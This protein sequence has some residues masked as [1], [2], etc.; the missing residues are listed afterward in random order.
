MVCTK[1]FQS[2]MSMIL[3]SHSRAASIGPPITDRVLITLEPSRLSHACFSVQCLPA[4]AL[5]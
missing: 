4:P 3:V 2:T 1:T 5:A